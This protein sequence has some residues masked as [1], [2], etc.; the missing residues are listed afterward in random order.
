MVVRY[1][2]AS[3]VEWTTLDP[4]IGLSDSESKLYNNFEFCEEKNHEHS[5]NTLI[6]EVKQFILTKKTISRNVYIS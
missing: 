6:Y 3:T 4:C 2:G 5:T 1:K